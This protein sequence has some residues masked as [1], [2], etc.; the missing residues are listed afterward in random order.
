MI[1]IKFAL[2]AEP[3]WDVNAEQGQAIDS[4]TTATE[5]VST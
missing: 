1:T 3:R 2:T 5:T 4:V